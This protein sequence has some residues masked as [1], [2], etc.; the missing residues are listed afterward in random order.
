MQTISGLTIAPTRLPLVSRAFFGRT[1][2]VDS[3]W[4]RQLFVEIKLAIAE[5]PKFESKFGMYP[6]LYVDLSVGQSLDC[7]A[8]HADRGKMM[9]RT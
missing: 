9:V 5:S 2:P 4:R 8:S 6:V 3:V 1:N 7:A